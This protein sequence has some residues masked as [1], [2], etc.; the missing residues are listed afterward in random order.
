MITNRGTWVLPDV[1]DDGVV[2]DGG[3]VGVVVVVVVHVHAYLH[4]LSTFL[5]RRDLT[6]T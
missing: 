4:L 2:V 6:L 5:S 1:V 3:V